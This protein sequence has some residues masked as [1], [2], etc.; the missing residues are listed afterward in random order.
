MAGERL[1]S[2][3]V[4]ELGLEGDRQWAFV[5]GAPHRAGK[6]LNIK[7]H[8]DLMRYRARLVGGR[9]VVAAPDGA[10]QDLDGALVKRLEVESS[11]PLQLRDAAGENFDDAPVLIVNLESV[12]AFSLEAGMPVDPRRFRANLYVDGLEPEAELAW[13]GRRIQAGEAELEVFS[14]CV[15]CVVINRDPDTTEVSPQLLDLM[16]ERHDKCMGMYCRVLRP[17]RV[18]V[19]DF[20]G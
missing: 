20:V 12:A 13:L 18:A 19:G 15:R 4:T 1:D 5:D 6:L 14:R 16:V 8:E 2:C 11:R 10:I 7:Q 3:M 9:P 17:G